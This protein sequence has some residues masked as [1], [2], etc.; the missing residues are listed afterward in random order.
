MWEW[1]AAY[2]VEKFTWPCGSFA[3]SVA[4]KLKKVID[5]EPT[6]LS[7]KAASQEFKS[8]V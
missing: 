8:Y 2:P 1:N 6:A 7:A 5:L 3:K 4:E